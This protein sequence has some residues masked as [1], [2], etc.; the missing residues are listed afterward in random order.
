MNKKRQK[1]RNGI[2]ITPLKHCSIRLIL[3]RLPTNV[4]EFIYPALEDFH[5]DIVVDRGPSARSIRI[6]LNPFTLIAAT[7]QAGKLSAPLRDRIGIQFNLNTYSEQELTHIIC[8][9]ANILHI[10]IT[11][12]TALVIAQR[13]RQTPRIANAL[14]KRIRDFAIVNNNIQDKTL[15]VEINTDITKHALKQLGIDDNGLNQLD[16][17]YLHTLKN[18]FNGGPAG[19]QA[20][21]TA[22]NENIYTIEE[23]IEP[24]LIIKNYIKRTPRGR[25][26]TS[27]QQ[28]IEFD[29]FS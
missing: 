20:I 7:T 21:A 11:Q 18:T 2:K 15:N 17:K 19:I 24:Y 25:I 28:P 27:T 9:A 29:L 8:R 4:E 10:N 26:I 16:R 22:I 23:Q 1:I 13:A 12:Q 3:H 14:L 6:E 5:L